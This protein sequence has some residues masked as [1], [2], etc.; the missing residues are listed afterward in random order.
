[1]KPVPVVGPLGTGHAG[2]V[3]YG[4]EGSAVR[5]KPQVCIVYRGPSSTSSGPQEAERRAYGRRPQ[6][7]RPYAP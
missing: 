6:P 3:A 7:A 1:M 4:G 5:R 2:G